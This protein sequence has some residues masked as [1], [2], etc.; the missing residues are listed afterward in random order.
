MTTNKI[1]KEIENKSCI[2]YKRGFQAGQKQKNKWI[3]L[4]RTQTLEKIKEIIR[5]KRWT[6]TE[7][8]EHKN[9]YFIA[10]NK[11]ID[12]ILKEIDNQQCKNNRLSG[13]LE[14]SG[15]CVNHL[16]ADSYVQRNKNISKLEDDEVKK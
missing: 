5:G 6:P 1:P 13:L 10:H 2:C 9:K 7:K 16:P 11:A 15:E 12:K 4:G 14:Q 3:A 8:N